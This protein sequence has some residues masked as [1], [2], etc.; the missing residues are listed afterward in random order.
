MIEE[1][2]PERL[3]NWMVSM[4]HNFSSGEEKIGW[5]KA[6]DISGHGMHRLS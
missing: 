3:H 6:I 2:M 4:C 1:Y 5:E